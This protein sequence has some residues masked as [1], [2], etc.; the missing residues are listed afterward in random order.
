M[1]SDDVVHECYRDPQVVQWVSRR[2]GPSVID[3]TG[4][5]DRPALGALVFDAPEAR[6]ELEAVIHP[7]IAQA[8][9]AWIADQRGRPSP[10]PLLVCEVPLLF[11][12]GLQDLFDAVLVVTASDEVRRRRVLERGQDFDARAAGQMAESQK[13]ALADHVY[14]NDGSLDQLEAWVAERYEQYAG[15]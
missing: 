5:V 14:V 12:V 3:E 6:R 11:E 9:T 8:R 4:G 7:R 1:S 10:P 2:F 15:R 13:V